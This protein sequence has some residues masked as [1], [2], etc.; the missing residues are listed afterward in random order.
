MGRLNVNVEHVETE[1]RQES[2]DGIRPTMH[3]LASCYDLC[4]WHKLRAS[5]VFKDVS[6]DRKCGHG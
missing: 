6:P 3:A 2:D 5:Y 1:R 4:G